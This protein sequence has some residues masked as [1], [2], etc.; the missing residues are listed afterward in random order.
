MTTNS[1]PAGPSRR[2]L[3]AYVAIWS[4]LAVGA[5]GYLT[6]AAAFPEQLSAIKIS[7]VDEAEVQGLKEL[8]QNLKVE[9]DG[10]RNE[11]AAVRRQRAEAEERARGLASR[12]AALEAP[13]ARP[14]DTAAAVEPRA[15]APAP[16]I[17]NAP[18][19]AAAAAPIE[20]GSIVATLKP[21]E[22]PV[23][24]KQPQPDPPSVAPARKEP[25]QKAVAAPPPPKKADGGFGT[26]EVKPKQ[27]A[28]ALQLGASSSLDMARLN[29]SILAD[30]NQ[31]LR[32]LQ[33]RVSKSDARG[34]ADPYNL[35]AG[36][37]GSREEA[38][39]LCGALE[40]RGV[41]CKVG[42]FG[43]DAL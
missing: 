33:P 43:G 16:R 18:E 7:G 26:T 30:Q 9:L 37:I 17:I 28:V 14:A 41:S 3:S 23:A 2:V 39:R 11:L 38:Q 4:V 32:S 40:Q 25:V 35:I 13:Q 20:T 24:D 27:P 42:S 34:A 1:Q 5:I 6:A 10:V 22:R 19:P 29:W 8:A 31:E 36:P 21:G 12:L 15:G